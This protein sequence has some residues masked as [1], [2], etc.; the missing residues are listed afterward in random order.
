MLDAE[1]KALFL[2]MADEYDQLA[3]RAA[4]HERYGRDGD[5]RSED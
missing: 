3:E 4:K 2:K 1:A 5:H